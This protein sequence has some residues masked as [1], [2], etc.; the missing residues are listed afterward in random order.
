MLE[1]FDDAEVY[2]NLII[3][4][5]F[6]IITIGIFANSL[7]ILMYIMNKKLRNSRNALM[8]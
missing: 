7:V 1:N 5:H 3:L 4:M 8:V 2:V 6:L